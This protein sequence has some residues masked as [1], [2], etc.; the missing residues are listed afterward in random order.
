M[1]THLSI[2]NFA[3]VK[4]LD[5][6]FS[7]GMTAITGETGAGKSISVDAL[8]LCLGERAD[9]GMVRTGADK[10]EV[11]AFFDITKLQAAQAWLQK[12]EL[13]DED[14]CLIRRVISA[15]GRSK[16]FVNG[17]PVSL[18]QLKDLGSNLLSIHGQ[19]A[20]QLILK[21]E[22]QRNL[23]DGV[24]DHQ[25]LLQAVAQTY[26]KLREQQK[27]YQ[28]L[29]EGQQ[30]RAD[31]CQL[32]AYQIQELDEFALADGEFNELEIDHKKLSHSQTLL[33]QTQI[34]FH[35]LYEADEF[36]ALSAVQNSLERLAELQEHDQSLGPIVNMLNEAAI[37]IEEA[38][39]ELRAYT[40]QLEIDPMRMQTVE[41][42]F[43]Q[44]LD[45]ARKH[46]VPA[47]E[48][49]DFHQQLS[50]EYQGLMKE[51]DLL[52]ELELQ[53][54]QSEQAYY[55]AAKKLSDSRQKAAL[56][57]AKQVQQHIQKMN[58]KDAEFAIDVQ[59]ITDNVPHKLGLDAV[60]FK[61]STNKGQAMDDLE[62]VVSGGELSRIGLAIQVIGSG[63]SQ[64]AT[65]IFDEV[66]SGISGA[67]ASI[68]GQ[69]LRK[70]GEQTQV[71][72]VTHLPQVA[73]RAHN[74]M[75][76]AKFSDEQT[77]ETHMICLEENERIDEL[78][79][80]LAGDTLT[81][82]AIANAKELLQ[83]SNS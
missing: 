13:A 76:V 16:A 49:Y 79:R 7:N 19:H 5:V 70:L 82:S 25:N 63:N 34:S 68:V 55:L 41:A 53:L 20:H 24:A 65:M 66:D 73:A 47:E 77:T 35:Q 42:R 21:S 36:N 62:K 74:Q 57:F 26:Q 59:H 72:C 48:L 15:E 44:A 67:T 12:N 60:R 56:N 29:E 58:M 4:T 71:I 11:S 2:R 28:Q 45:L 33:E 18:Q 61:V 37:Q 83:I 27:R 80:L 6:D 39:Q 78:A 3:V 23:L 50:N 81:E 46:H 8:G 69:L 22:Q 40:D 38:A 32:L 30:Q 52:E 17:I 9:S 10:A 43:S 54:R 64:V 31:R 1:L 51:D 75:F 14:E